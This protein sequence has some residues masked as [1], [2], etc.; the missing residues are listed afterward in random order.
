[1]LPPGSET[2]GYQRL[3]REANPQSYLGYK[4]EI[5]LLL[6]T[7]SDGFKRVFIG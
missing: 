5:Q 4:T 2:L 3:Q 7:I 6:F 1:M